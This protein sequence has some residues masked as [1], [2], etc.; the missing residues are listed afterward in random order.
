MPADVLPTADMYQFCASLYVMG[1][2]LGLGLCV[3]FW[4]VGGIAA[5]LLRYLRGG[6]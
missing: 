2:A 6:A 5:S 1:F 3:P 4:L